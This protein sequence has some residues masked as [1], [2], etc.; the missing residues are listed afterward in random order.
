MTELLINLPDEEM[1]FFMSLLERL[2]FVKIKQVEVKKTSKTK[3]RTPEQQ[4]FIDDLKV[5]LQEVELHL[6]GK[7][8]LQ[9]A[10]EFLAE[11]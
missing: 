1:P 8:K 6:Q 2:D 10:R 11:L 9:S 4:E 3:V 5:S 7:I